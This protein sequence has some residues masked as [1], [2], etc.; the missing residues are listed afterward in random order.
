MQRSAAL[1][2]WLPLS[3]SFGIRFL[4]S[5]HGALRQLVDLCSFCILPEREA[6]FIHRLGCDHSQGLGQTT[7]AICRS[8]RIANNVAAASRFL[9]RCFE[10]CHVGRKPITDGDRHL[11]RSV[12]VYLPGC[13]PPVLGWIASVSEPFNVLVQNARGQ[14]KKIVADADCLIE[15][16][17]GR[18]PKKHCLQQSRTKALN[19]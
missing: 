10:A 17:T 5:L 14:F 18:H 2:A 11:G 9:D 19:L 15:D 7:A 6:L 16:D 13:R 12:L 4:P 1:S 3:S 8:S